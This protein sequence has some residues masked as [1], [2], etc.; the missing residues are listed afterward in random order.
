MPGD[1]QV[2][3]RVHAVGLNH[4]ELTMLKPSSAGGIVGRV[5]ASDAA[6]EVVSVGKNVRGIRKGERVVSMYFNNWTGGPYSEAVLENAHGWTTDGVLAQYVALDSTAV[7]P[8]P[9]AWSYDEA[10][11]LSTSGVTAWNAL[12]RFEAVR[13]SDVVLIQGTGGVSTFAMQFAVASGAR[14]IVT[15]SSDDKLER[16]MSMGAHNGINYR[17]EPEWSNHVRQL[18]DGHGADIVVDVG[19]KSTLAQSVASLADG[20]RLAIVGGLSGYNGEIS[21]WGLIQ[22][23]AHAHGV[24]VGSRADYLQMIAFVT[25]HHIRPVIERVYPL[26]QYEDALRLLASGNFIGKI[27]IRL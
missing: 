21:A 3:I 5:P 8:M 24:F 26:E 10:A 6:G 13:P 25:R 7:A 17:R 22:K 12:M 9:A 2:L 4:G 15:S 23:S 20:G 14:V 11:T 27:V 18:T 19:G 1:H 16:V